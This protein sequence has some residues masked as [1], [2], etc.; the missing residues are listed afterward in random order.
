MIH[1]SAGAWDC[2]HTDQ[3]KQPNM[4]QAS[5]VHDCIV[6]G[7]GPA[8]STV[9]T[10]LADYGHKVLLL[11]RSNFPRHHIGESLMPQTYWT[12]QRIGMLE[13]LKASDFPIKESVQ[14]VSS[15]GHESQPYFF[16]D[17]DPNEWSFTWQVKRDRFDKMMLEN[18]DEHGVEVREGV[19]VKEVLF[20][21]GRAAGVRVLCGRNEE[22]ITARVVVDA[23][24]N[25]G[26]LSRQLKIREADAGLRNAAMYA[27]Y[28]GAHRDPGRNAGATLVINTPDKRGWFWS[29]P[30]PDDITSIGVVAPTSYLCLGRGDDPLA[31]LA[32]EIA[33]CPGI[34]RRV[35][36]A[37]RV[38]QA[39][40]TGDYTYRSR[41]IAG[42]GWVLAGDAFGF[43]DPIYSSGVFLA[44]KSG[45]YAADAVHDALE[46]GDL[47]GE[48]LG[49]FGPEYLRGMQ[50]IRQLVYAF[51]EPDFSFGR[52]NRDY[53]EHHD[54][55]VR[56]LIGDVFNDGFSD[57]FAAIAKT[58]K[59]PAP[60][61]LD[62]PISPSQTART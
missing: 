13:K 56:L 62:K 8:G 6:I 34:R 14:F 20:E 49:R 10:I 12:F 2:P 47:C 50:L 5:S 32:E 40:V 36:S 19:N 28:K 29:I 61:P 59:L 27:Y 54:N 52:F 44:L 42:D 60:V 51:Y 21:N 37:E 25:N 18:A 48:R 57:T 9:A 31:I 55:I 4:N 38:S 24:G 15:S 43:L 22:Q 17:R 30:L 35:E 33:N 53:P 46:S 16:P 7:G 39:Y 58:A 11:E 41:S 1:L 23:S 3:V 45:E 26:L